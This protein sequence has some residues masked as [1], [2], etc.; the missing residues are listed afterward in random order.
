MAL[1]ERGLQA[2]KYGVLEHMVR[3]SVGAEDTNELLQGVQAA[4]DQV[5]QTGKAML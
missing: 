5:E 3:I 4:L 2:A 1:T